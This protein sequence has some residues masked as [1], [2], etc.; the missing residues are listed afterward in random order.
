MTE[1]PD[2]TTP[3]GH[4]E[5]GRDEAKKKFD[6]FMSLKYVLPFLANLAPEPSS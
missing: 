5:A 6:A 1:K 2:G 4:E 3:S